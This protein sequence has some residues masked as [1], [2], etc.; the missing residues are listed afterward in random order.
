MVV[1]QFS[2]LLQFPV[3]LSHAF[4]YHT[5]CCECLYVTDS[6]F[7]HAVEEGT[8]GMSSNRHRYLCGP[9]AC[10]DDSAEH[11][12]ARM[13]G[14]GHGGH[15]SY[16]PQPSLRL[17]TL[18][19]LLVRHPQQPPS[20]LIPWSPHLLSRYSGATLVLFVSPFE[21]HHFSGGLFAQTKC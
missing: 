21:P 2:C 10:P 15:A 18:P 3:L 5:A 4:Y 17:L 19:F 16:C 20:L 14:P 1:T 6:R 11:R 8:A 7:P 12:P 13:R 9:D